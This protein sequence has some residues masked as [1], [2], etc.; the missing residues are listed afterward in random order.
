MIAEEC[1]DEHVS[2]ERQIAQARAGLTSAEPPGAQ[3]TLDG[4][5]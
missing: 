5:G 1:D 4:T 2:A 3:L